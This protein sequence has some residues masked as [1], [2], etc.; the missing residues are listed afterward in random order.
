M[1]DECK[2]TSYYSKIS[3]KLALARVQAKDDPKREKT[4]VR[5]YWCPQHKAFHLT[6][7]KRR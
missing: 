1:P 7:R 4:E 6:S 2:K 3:A 5:L